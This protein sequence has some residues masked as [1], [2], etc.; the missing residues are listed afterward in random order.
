MI[1]SQDLQ[2]VLDRGENQGDVFSLYLDLSVNSNNKRTHDVFIAKQRSRFADQG[3]ARNE[4]LAERVEVFLDRVER[5]LDADFDESNAGAAFFSPAA[6][7]EGESLE[8]L[9][10]PVPFE[11]QLCVSDSPV[12][13][14]LVR[15][16]GAFH[17]HGILVVDREHLRMLSA[18]MGRPQAEHEVETQPYPTSHDVRRG[19]YSAKDFQSRKAEEVRHFFKEFAQEVHEF[20]RRYS[21]DDFVVLGTDENVSKFLEFLPQNIRDRVVQTGHAAI[22]ESSSEILGRL[23]TWFDAQQERRG[24]DAVVALKQRVAEEHYA[25]AGFPRTLEQLQEGKVETLVVGRGLEKKGGRCTSCS[26]YLATSEGACPY[27]GGTVR[28]GVD[29]VETM[30]R[31]AAESD[32][33]VAFAEPATLDDYE[34]VGALL[35]F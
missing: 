19:G 25:T 23:R 35:R 6:P 16:L 10:V 18:Y 9:Q 34:G 27:C 20:D 7:A 22:D 24:A 29:L 31:L 32:A 14:P 4:R 2:R 11:N 17:H 13:S 8:V 15:L 21:P 12:V 1:S 3:G 33:E 30:V 5:W 28:D 26:F